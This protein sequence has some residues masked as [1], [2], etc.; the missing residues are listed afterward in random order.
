MTAAVIL[1]LWA[2][3]HHGADE[4]HVDLQ[5]IER[6]S[7]QVQ[8]ARIAGAEV[9]ERKP[10]AARLEIG[11]IQRGKCQVVEPGRFP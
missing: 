8:Q 4:A 9:V 7:L 1:R 6:Q 2:R 3:L 10:H 5:L 11:G